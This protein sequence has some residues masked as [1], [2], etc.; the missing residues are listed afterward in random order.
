MTYEEKK[1]YLNLVEDIM[2]C[3]QKD[4][5][6][7]KEDVKAR[8]DAL[9]A[10]VAGSTKNEF[11]AAI[12]LGIPRDWVLEICNIGDELGEG[13][14]YE[15][16]Y[17]VSKNRIIHMVGLDIEIPSYEWEF[18][19]EDIDKWVE[20]KRKEW[21]KVEPV[22]PYVWNRIKELTGYNRENYKLILNLSI[23]HGIL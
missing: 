3:L 22:V 16:K 5:E 7:C 9:Q 2:R 6:D 11:Q 14:S 20:I 4:V 21:K 10:Y 15:E 19:P 8:I 12:A 23:K 1:D 17:E 13:A 18:T